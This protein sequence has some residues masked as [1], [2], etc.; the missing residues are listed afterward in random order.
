MYLRIN[1]FALIAFLALN[2]QLFY[3]QEEKSEVEKPEIN[4]DRWSIEGNVGQNKAIRPFSSG[5]YTSDPTIYFNFSGVDHFDLGVRY[6]ISTHFGL[7]LDLGYDIIESQ[8]GS[9]SLPFETNQYRIG[10]QGVANLGRILKFESFT[11]RLGILGHAGVQ[12]TQ[13]EPQTGINKGKSEHNGGIMLGLTP[14]LK[15]TNWM[16]LTADFTVISNVRQHF[17]WDGTYSAEDNNLS[18][19]MYNTTLGLTFYLGKKEQHADW[20]IEPVKTDETEDALK[21]ITNLETMLKDSDKDG[22]PDYLDLEKDTPSGVAVDSHGRFLDINKNGIPDQLERDDTK[23]GDST[24]NQNPDNNVEVSSMK[25]LEGLIAEGDLNV[26]YNVSEHVP[27]SGSVQTVYWLYQYLVK[28]P[29][30]KITLVGYADVRGTSE[31]NTALSLRRA[32]YLK[33][34][35]V[36][37]GISSSRINV[38]G[39]GV[40]NS[41]NSKTTTGLDLARRVMIQLNN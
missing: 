41:F 30:A 32:Q 8:N 15:I 27:N 14:Q 34:F 26:F 18:G 29:E 38:R 21:R 36:D 7:K 24:N 22:V 13:I 37:S 5:Y 31:A 12:V 10:L 20:Y 9:G 19:L 3:A 16:S 6:M 1:K 25:A 2:V 23:L 17:N 35:M 40:D 33:D 39:A 11:S 4:F 28:N